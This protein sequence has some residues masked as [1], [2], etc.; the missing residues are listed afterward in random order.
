MLGPVRAAAGTAMPGRERDGMNRSLHGCRCPAAPKG[1]P[2]SRAT[3][4]GVEWGWSWPPR[5]CRWVSAEHRS[6]LMLGGH[7]GGVGVVGRGAPRGAGWHDRGG[8]GPL[9][10]R[11]GVVQ[12][13]L[14]PRIVTARRWLPAGRART[15]TAPRALGST[16]GRSPSAGGAAPRL[17]RCPLLTVAT[18]RTG[19]WARGKNSSGSASQQAASC[20]QSRSP[21]ARAAG[22]GV[23]VSCSAV[24]GWPASTSRSSQVSAM[25]SR[26]APNTRSPPRSG[27]PRSPPEGYIHADEYRGCLFA[28]CCLR[29]TVGGTRRVAGRPD[30]SSWWIESGRPHYRG[31]GYRQD[32]AGH[33]V[34]R[35]GGRPRRTGELGPGI[36][37]RGSARPLALDPDRTGSAPSVGSSRSEEIGAPCGTPVSNDAAAQA[38]GPTHA[39][40]PCSNRRERL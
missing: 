19:A 27:I 25:R 16:V 3:R 36:R 13:A 10:G 8:G 32:G 28:E 33:S 30:R 29:R 24:V 18:W 5:R 6:P 4:V 14:R 17:R 1:S 26:A 9:L 22:G 11:A 35:G 37:K 21:P 39:D 40:R 34:D 31:A 2:S 15:T 12:N 23:A 38:T 7:A 20:R